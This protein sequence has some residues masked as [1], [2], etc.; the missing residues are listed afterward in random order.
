MVQGVGA[1]KGAYKNKALFTSYLLWYNVT[2][3]KNL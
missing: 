3:F 2:L 1:Y